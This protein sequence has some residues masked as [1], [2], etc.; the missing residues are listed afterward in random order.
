MKDIE[1]PAA[2]SVA[3]AL[4]SACGS[5]SSIET[6]CVKKP[7]ILLVEPNPELA[8]TRALLLA[9]LGYPVH[10]A[11]DLSEICQQRGS[12]FRLVAV[13]VTPPLVTLQVILTTIRALWPQARIL[14]LGENALGVEDHQY[15]ERVAAAHHPADVVDVARRLIGTS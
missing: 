7:G 4:G 2:P 11:C 1:D 12:L 5:D 14:L 15:D 10:I 8:H 13:D 3:L 6:S 9:S